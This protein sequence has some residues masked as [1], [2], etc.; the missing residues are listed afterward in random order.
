MLIGKYDEPDKVKGSFRKLLYQENIVGYVL[1][2]RDNTKPIF[3]SP[4]NNIGTTEA[5]EWVARLITKYRIPEP[6]RLADKIVAKYKK[7]H[8]DEIKI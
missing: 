7:E 2:S 8:L 3:I 4:G 1:R 6:T 5:R